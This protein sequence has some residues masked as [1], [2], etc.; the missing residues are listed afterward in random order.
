MGVKY[1]MTR[2][3]DKFVILII[4]DTSKTKRRGLFN[5]ANAIQ[6]GKWTGGRVNIV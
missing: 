5:C 1:L 4:M 6:S 3:P 2:I